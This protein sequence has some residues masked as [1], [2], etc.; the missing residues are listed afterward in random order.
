MSAFCKHVTKNRLSSVGYLQQSS[1]V[2]VRVYDICQKEEEQILILNWEVHSPVLLQIRF[3]KNV[4]EKIYFN[5]LLSVRF[6]LLVLS[7][8]NVHTSLSYTLP[9]LQRFFLCF[10]CYNIFDLIKLPIKSSPLH[11]NHKIKVK[12]RNEITFK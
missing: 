3:T 10:Y 5:N 6:F 7:Q 2:C 11:E 1:A 12:L 9:L 8:F 4:Q